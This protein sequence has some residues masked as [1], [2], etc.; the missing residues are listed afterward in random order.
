MVDAASGSPRLM[1]V[2]MTRAARRASRID[3][4][5]GTAVRSHQSAAP[6]LTRRATVLRYG[7]AGER[8][9][10]LRYGETRL[11]MISAQAHWAGWNPRPE[12]FHTKPV[13][14]RPVSSSFSDHG[15]PIH[16]SAV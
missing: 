9:A 6:S 13:T 3:G 8:N 15:A 5:R 14:Y 16:P 7:A 11:K 10:Q 12:V 1:A 2:T 4:V